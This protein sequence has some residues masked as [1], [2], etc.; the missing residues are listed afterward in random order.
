MHEDEGVIPETTGNRKAMA[1]PGEAGDRLISA[2]E[3]LPVGPVVGEDADKRADKAPALILQ[4]CMASSP[5]PVLA[6]ARCALGSTR[7]TWH[8]DRWQKGAACAATACA[9][10]DRPIAGARALS[11]TQR[12]QHTQ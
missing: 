12:T 10:A 3:A 2:L 1:S 7:H 11:R 5:A 4:L 9:G 6:C 8:Q